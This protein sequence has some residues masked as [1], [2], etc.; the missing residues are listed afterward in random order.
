MSTTTT[1]AP[2][3]SA[4]ARGRGRGRGGYRGSGRGGYGSNRAAASAAAGPQEAPEVAALRQK[5]GDELPLVQ[6]VFPDWD[7]ESI[8]FALGE[9]AGQAEVAI[10]RIAE[11]TAYMPQMA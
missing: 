6:A 5:Y 7:D 10:T 2:T 11:G 1:T 9:A 8:L 3:A 4:P